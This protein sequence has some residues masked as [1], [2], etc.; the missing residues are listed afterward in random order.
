MRIRNGHYRIAS[1]I[2][3]ARIELSAFNLPLVQLISA[4]FALDRHVESLDSGLTY[5][6]VVVFHENRHSQQSP[7]EQK[8]HIYSW[9]YA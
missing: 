1:Q 2:Q 4:I 9:G 7:N 5:P 3:P 8:P 6:T